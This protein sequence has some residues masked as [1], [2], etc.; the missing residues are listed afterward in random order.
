VIPRHDLHPESERMFESALWMCEKAVLMSE[1]ARAMYWAAIE[2][3][4]SSIEMRQQSTPMPS[5]LGSYRIAQSDYRA[6][7]TGMLDDAI[8]LTGADMGN[9]QL[10]DPGL[11]TL[12]IE[13]QHGFGRAFLEFF[14]HVHSGQFACGEAIKH[15]STVVVEDVTLSPIFRDTPS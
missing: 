3:T 9:I 6:T 15:M 8:A 5:R 4:I 13:V 1:Q 14:A 7:L 2:A 12:N 10:L 11:Q